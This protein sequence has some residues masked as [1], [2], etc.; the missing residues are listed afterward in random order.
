[1]EKAGE[2]SNTKLQQQIQRMPEYKGAELT[3]VEDPEAGSKAKALS[4]IGYRAADGQRIL[5]PQSIEQTQI[6]ASELLGGSLKGLNDRLKP[7]GIALSRGTGEAEGLL[8]LDMYGMHEAS[9][10]KSE[11]PRVDIR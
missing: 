4:E 1:M 5:V 8:N 7:I 11:R 9:L 3:F 6:Q 10:K 2:E